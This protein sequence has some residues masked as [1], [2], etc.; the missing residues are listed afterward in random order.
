VA[1]LRWCISVFYTIPV[2]IAVTGFLI[3]VSL[4]ALPFD[5]RGIAVAWVHR[6][7]AHWILAI[8]R[9]KVRCRG[10]EKID[11]TGR[12][13]CV[14]NHASLID[15]PVLVAYFPLRLCF[16][17]KEELFRIPVFG[18]YLRRTRHIP[19]A[20]DD[21]RAAAKSMA[22]AAR[23]IAAGT[24]SV[25]LF[26]EG[27]RSPSG[28][29]IFKEGAA[30]LAIRSGVPIL[31]LAISGTPGIWPARSVVIT[32]GTAEVRVGEE[33]PTAGIRAGARGELT[34]RLRREIEELLEA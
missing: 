2:C 32:P 17:A 8:C 30:L 25:L 31:P 7:W 6:L 9:V 27:T 26:P 34:L 23:A 4:C 33:V 5:P 1:I 21:R 29:G 10:L 24:R 28:L 14:A 18:T 19:V 13:I 12:Y 22:N 16:L 11:P 20:R 15:I 3:G